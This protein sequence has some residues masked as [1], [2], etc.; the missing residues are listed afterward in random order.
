MDSFLYKDGPLA[1]AE[2]GEFIPPVEEDSMFIFTIMLSYKHM[3]AAL[4]LNN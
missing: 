2:E 3:H 4:K 1:I